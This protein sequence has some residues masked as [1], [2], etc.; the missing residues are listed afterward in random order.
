MGMK[1]LHTIRRSSADATGAF[2]KGQR[3]AALDVFAFGG[4]ERLRKIGICAQPLAQVT[5]HAGCLEPSDG[6]ARSDACEPIQRRERLA[7]HKRERLDDGG[8]SASTTNRDVH[9]AAHRSFDLT[10]DRCAIVGVER[11]EN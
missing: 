6:T 5:H 9:V 10:L 2:Q 7:V 3:V 4:G 1:T 8:Q 11:R